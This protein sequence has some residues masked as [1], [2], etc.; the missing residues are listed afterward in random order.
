MVDGIIE[1]FTTRLILT[2][3]PPILDSKWRHGQH[4]QSFSYKYSI[5]RI[6]DSGRTKC[7]LTQDEIQ[8]LERKA[9]EKDWERGIAVQLMGRL[10]LRV[11]EVPYP[12]DNNLRWSDDGECWF[13]TVRGK[14]TTGGKKTRDA[15]LPNDVEDDIRKYSRERGKSDNEAWVSASNPSIRRWVSEAGDALADETENERWSYVSS[16]DL[17]R[18]WATYHLVEREVDVR[19]MMAVGGWSSYEAIEPYLAKPTESRIGEA[20]ESD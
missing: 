20:M 8:K 7:W 15:W 1:L 12:S 11:S 18:S 10:G 14:D 3:L 16:H 13:V 6:D 9:S 19:T 4:L 5:M 17:R 2:N